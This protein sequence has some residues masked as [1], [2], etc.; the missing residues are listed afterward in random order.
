MYIDAMEHR[1]DHFNLGVKYQLHVASVP[2]IQTIYPVYRVLAFSDCKLTI[3]Q[4]TQYSNIIK[5][6]LLTS[7]ISFADTV[8]VHHIFILSSLDIIEI[9]YYNFVIVFKVLTPNHF[10]VIVVEKGVNY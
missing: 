5:W 6:T 3:T 7:E 9:S 4:W 8:T 2:H 10:V 1:Y